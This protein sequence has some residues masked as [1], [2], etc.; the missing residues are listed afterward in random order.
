M[1]MQ[2]IPTSKESSRMASAE[3]ST[4]AALDPVLSIAGLNVTFATSSGLVEAVRGV[5]LTASKGEIVAIVG[6]SGSGKSVTSR[7]I[8]GL[9]PTNA[10]V[11]GSI[12]LSGEELVG[13]NEERF[14]EVRGSRISMVF[15]EPSRALNPVF[16]IGSQMVDTIRIHRGVS[17][18]EARDRAIEMLGLVG[19]PEPQERL[20]YYP[21]QLSGG[22]KQ[23]VMIATA[24]SCDPELIIADEPTTA[25][26]VTVQAE[27]L[28][29]L[30]DLRDRLGTTILLITHNMGVVADIADRVVVMNQGRIVETAGTFELF[31]AP[32][33]AYT[34][35]LLSVVPQLQSVE[36]GGAE[37]ELVSTQEP[38][39]LKVS[40]L[41]VRFSRGF[42]R[43]N[44][45]AVDDVSFALGAG[46]TLAIVG[47]SGSG[48][49][50]V[51]KTIAG[52]Q[53]PTLGTVRLHGVDPHG[54]NGR[55]ARE[56]RR[57]VGYIFQDPNGSLNPHHRV[58]ASIGAPLSLER[59]HS[60]KQIS[61]RIDELL[62]AVRLPRSIRTKYPHQLSG[63]QSQRVAIARALIRRPSL[64]IADEP[65]SA[66]DVSVQAQVLTLLEELKDD[67]GFACLFITHDLAV[68]S[69]FADTAVVMS[70]GR[71]VE[72]GPAV[73]VLG[74]PQAEYTKKLVAA[75]PIADPV[76][77]RARRKL[78]GVSSVS[79]R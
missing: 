9:H 62:D 11:A 55:R 20:G 31:A 12:K 60:S 25:L 66:L 10:T 45:L 68:A 59:G 23:R 73:R 30:R 33:D 51:A 14:N 54:S 37:T 70:K 36:A 74:D 4:E 26:D 63:G 40:E 18:K 50:T 21:H 65:T 49:S 24:V 47:E 2:P 3:R 78:I 13:L 72:H 16:T 35:T 79:S 67:L 61:N 39:I 56:L 38:A 41:T 77:Q 57:G 17:R 5:D 44:F 42:G 48:K 8:L 34:R 29:L 6:E 64:L 22:Q 75:L 53:K 43:G 32:K 15:Q 46:E 52:L 7:A 69:S 19:I 71:V 58:E 27:I 28:R 76:R 1:S